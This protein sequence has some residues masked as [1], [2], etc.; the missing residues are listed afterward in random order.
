VK[1]VKRV[2]A[3]PAQHS[4]GIEFDTKGKLTSQELVD[5]LADAGIKATTL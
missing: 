1:G 5:A 3:Y 4:V 2:V